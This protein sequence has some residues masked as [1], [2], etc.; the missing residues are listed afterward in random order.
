MENQLVGFKAKKPK[1]YNPEVFLSQEL[2]RKTEKK[3][4]N[5]EGSKVNP[6]R[7]RN[8]LLKTNKQI[9]SNRCAG[10]Q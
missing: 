1:V 10:E 9:W 5:L 7:S 6:W 3:K 8:K 4:E 2:A